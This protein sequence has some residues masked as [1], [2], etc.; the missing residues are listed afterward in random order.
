MGLHVSHINLYTQKPQELAHFFSE[1]LDMDI[2]PGEGGEGIWVENSDLKLYVTQASATQL[3]HK[4]GERDL[5]LEF[6]LDNLNELE[7]LLQKVQ[8]LSYRQNT[9]Q[10]PS[11][12]EKAEGK[13]VPKVKLSKVKDKVFFNLKDPDGRRWK[14][15]YSQKL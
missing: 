4:G 6:K 5:Q 10:H 2:R 3:F 12:E 15:S 1:L 7:D 13:A 9:S 14:F 8:F 11:D